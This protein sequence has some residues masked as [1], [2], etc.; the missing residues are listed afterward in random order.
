MV[1]VGKV[2]HLSLNIKDFAIAA[3][4]PKIDLPVDDIA[5]EACRMRITFI[6]T[7]PAFDLSEI[8]GRS[9]SQPAV[10]MLQLHVKFFFGV[11]NGHH[12]SDALLF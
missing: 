12:R 7:N 5:G 1:F 11:V 6:D 9:C 2:V 3:P 4:T 10:R 8:T